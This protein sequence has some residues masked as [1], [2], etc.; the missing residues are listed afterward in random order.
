MKFLTTAIAATLVTS[1]ALAQD[2]KSEKLDGGVSI[3]LSKGWKVERFVNP[4]MNMPSMKE[5]MVG[6]SETRLRKGS[7]GV[8]VSYMHFKTDKKP[9]GMD[10]AALASQEEA[11]IRAGTQYLRQSVETEVSPRS[12]IVGELGVSLATLTAR[13]G[14]K[15]NV[16]AGYPGGCVTTGSIRRGAAVWAVSVASDSC[17]SSTHT[18]M[19]DALYSA[20]SE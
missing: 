17:S 4:A 7:T 15:F 20:S 8:L 10:E 13:S 18:E 12:E 5:M 2:T 11:V 14:E 9:D 6:A 1:A 19:V 16:R 3:A